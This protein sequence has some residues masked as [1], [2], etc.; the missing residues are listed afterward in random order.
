MF[1]PKAPKV[2]KAL[3]LTPLLIFL[4][5]GLFEIRTFAL[6]FFISFNFTAISLSNL[7]IVSLILNISD[8][9]L[10]TSAAVMLGTNRLASVLANF[11][12]ASF[13]RE[14]VLLAASERAFIFSRL[15]E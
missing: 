7:E 6:N 11:L 10:L 4:A 2:F 1:A 9:I 5:T 12:N 15:K 14:F 13:R 3:I 8:L